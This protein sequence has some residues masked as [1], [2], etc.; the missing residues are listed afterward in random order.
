MI[1]DGK[2][3]NGV[4]VSVSI[5]NVIWPFVLASKGNPKK[6]RAWV[7]EKMATCTRVNSAV[8]LTFIMHEIAKPNLSKKVLGLAT[9]QA[10]I[11]D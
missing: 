10:D 9:D 2:D 7:R 5:S 3:Q 11:E 6:A 1:I 4:R 8:I